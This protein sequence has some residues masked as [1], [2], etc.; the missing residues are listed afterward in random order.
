[1]N[2]IYRARRNM[3]I[4]ISICTLTCIW[5]PIFVLYF[6]ARNTIIWDRFYKAIIILGFIS[7]IY[8][9]SDIIYLK[10][11]RKEYAANK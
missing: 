4:E 3:C 11:I 9:I 2:K 8:I 1:M 6:C 5:T 7:F 10:R